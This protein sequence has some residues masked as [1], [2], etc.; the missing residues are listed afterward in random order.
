MSQ[1]TQ[2]I[3]HC[4]LCSVDSLD[5]KLFKYGVRHYACSTCGLKKWGR[6]FLNM[7]PLHEARQIEFVAISDLGITLKDLRKYFGDRERLNLHVMPKFDAR[8]IAAWIVRN[9]ADEKAGRISWSEFSIRNEAAWS[10]AHRFY[11]TVIGSPASRRSEKVQRELNLQM[12]GKVPQVVSG[13]ELMRD[14]ARAK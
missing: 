5:A 8:Q 13:P 14:F 3:N 9:C 6:E 4:R 7:L 12:H 10:C 1:Y 11:L 2:P